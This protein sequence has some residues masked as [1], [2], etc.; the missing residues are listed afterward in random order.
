MTRLQNASF[1]LSYLNRIF[2]KL[3]WKHCQVCLPEILRYNFK[4]HTQT[5][6]YHD[7]LRVLRVGSAKHLDTIE[8]NKFSTP[9]TFHIK[10]WRK[11]V[12]MFTMKPWRIPRPCPIYL[13][14][15]EKEKQPRTRKWN[16]CQQQRSLCQSSGMT[17]INLMN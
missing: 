12:P 2:M 9:E 5:T 8:C 16:Q 13:F 1:G 11:P 6:I 10:N 14:S 3:S 17:A 7:R 15:F 4:G